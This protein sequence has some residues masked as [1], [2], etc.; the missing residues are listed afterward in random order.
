ML[1]FIKKIF[2]RNPFRPRRG[3]VVVILDP[4]DIQVNLYDKNKAYKKYLSISNIIDELNFCM[5]YTNSGAVI[6]DRYI[7]EKVYLTYKDVI[8]T[9]DK[10]VWILDKGNFTKRFIEVVWERAYNY[11]SVWPDNFEVTIKLKLIYSNGEESVICIESKKGDHNL[12]INHNI[13]HI[14]KWSDEK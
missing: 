3:K 11:F 6:L 14:F 7:P 1:N 2:N 13:K 9:E 8:Y 5:Q 10:Y 12:S 4:N